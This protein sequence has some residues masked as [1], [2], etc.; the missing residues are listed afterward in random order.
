MCNGVL[1]ARIEDRRILIAK[2]LGQYDRI[3]PLDPLFAGME[4]AGMPPLPGEAEPKSDN[5]SLGVVADLYCAS[6]KDKEWV[7]KTYMDNRRI[8]N[9][10]GELLGAGRPIASLGLEDVRAVRDTLQSLP[11][12]YMKS[13]QMKDMPLK[14]VLAIGPSGPVIAVKTQDK[15]FTYFRSFLNWCV[16]EGYIATMPG[17]KL[18][19]SGAS[20]SQAQEAR[21]PFS[22]GQLQA[23]FGSPLFTGHKSPGRR[24]EPGTMIIRDGKFWIPLIALYS[25]LRLGEI[26]QLLVADLKDPD[27]LPYFDISRGEDEE[28]QLK[29]ASSKRVVPVHPVLIDLGF[30]EHVEAQR[31]AQPKGRIF[32]EIEPG[33]D[34]Y[35][36]AN[37]SKWF[38]RYAKA[39][40]VKTARTSFHSFRHN[41]K[42]ACTAAGVAESHS[43]A[44][45]GHADGSVH[46][47]YGS[48]IPI[49]VLRE[50][51]EK[52]SYPVDLNALHPSAKS[53]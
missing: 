4:A 7:A 10:V 45:M 5:R 34:G 26:V 30:M 8:L 47:T 29:T 35:F 32:A 17:P 41:F 46:A 22:T 42:D 36:S 11:S 2:L 6:K 33:Q 49:H 39:V 24:T 19:I 3:A 31:K 25:G 21:Y 9:L 12:N 44:L 23:L 15:Y 18:K 38:S 28:K 40:K 16:S 13:K 48:K 50:T 20:K 53:L 27:G 52:V 1:R 51:V 14:E 43:K 37:F